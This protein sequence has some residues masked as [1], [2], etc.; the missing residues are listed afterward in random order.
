MEV[1]DYWG[2]IPIIMAQII[3]M[4]ILI[5]FNLI[6]ILLKLVIKRKDLANQSIPYWS[7]C[8]WLKIGT[9]CTLTLLP[10]SRNCIHFLCLW[11]SFVFSLTNVSSQVI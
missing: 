1:L 3:E 8:T 7:D 11:S 9:Y 2:M 6:S 4:K 10:Q 5:M